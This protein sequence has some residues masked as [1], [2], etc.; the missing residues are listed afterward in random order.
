MITGEIIL[1]QQVPAAA[2]SGASGA[3]PM[4]SSERLERVPMFGM[5]QPTNEQS[6]TAI[7]GKFRLV[8]VSACAFFNP[9]YGFC[10]AA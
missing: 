4:I 9:D 2:P 7:S 10:D 8:I 6:A 5:S 3:N 1:P